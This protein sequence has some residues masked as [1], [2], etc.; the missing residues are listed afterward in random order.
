[1][2]GVRVERL[3][4][5][6]KKTLEQRY[7]TLERLMRSVI[8]KFKRDTPSPLEIA[9]NIPQVLGLLESP[10]DEMDLEKLEGL[11]G[12]ALPE[13]INNRLAE[14]KNYFEDL[15]R[16][17]I[18]LD[19]PKDPLSLAVGSLFSCNHCNYHQGF[20]EAMGHFCSRRRIILEGE[21]G[22]FVS[23]VLRNIYPV[24]KMWNKTSFRSEAKKLADYV[25]SC[26]LDSQTATTADLDAVEIRLKCVEHSAGRSI[27]PILTWRSAVCWPRVLA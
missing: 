2:A 13:Y 17:D 15:V 26:D 16:K 27:V 18:E 24:P 8:P 23:F 25:R 14:A 7:K 11:I 10:Q 20:P 4:R 5:E 12:R 19:N 21:A 22:E 9:I 1:M 6:R 3:A